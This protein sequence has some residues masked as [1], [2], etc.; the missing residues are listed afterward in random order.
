M[1]DAKKGVPNFKRESCAGFSNARTAATCCAG[2]AQA[3]S[4]ASCWGE[5]VP[6]PD[7]PMSGR[8]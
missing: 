5:K 1:K 3:I 4:G 2:V 7:R 8:R 6:S